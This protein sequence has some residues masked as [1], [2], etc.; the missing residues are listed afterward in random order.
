[1]GEVV[2][3]PVDRMAN[4]DLSAKAFSHAEVVMFWGVARDALDGGGQEE[5]EWALRFIGEAMVD[6]E[7]N[8]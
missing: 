8:A 5:L 6:K 2:R 3:L 1:M 7:Y 4:P